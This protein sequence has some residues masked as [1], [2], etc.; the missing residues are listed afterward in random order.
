[1][2]DRLGNRLRHIA[3]LRDGEQFQIARGAPK[4]QRVIP[5]MAYAWIAPRT[6]QAANLSGDV[7]VVN[8]QTL[9]RQRGIRQTCHSAR[10]RLLRL[11]AYRT[12]PALSLEQRGVFRQANSEIAAQLS[13]S[14]TVASLDV[15]SGKLPVEKTLAANGAKALSALDGSQPQSAVAVGEVVFRLQQTAPRAADMSRW[16][17]LQDKFGHRFLSHV[18]CGRAPTHGRQ[19]CPWARALIRRNPAAVAMVPG[20]A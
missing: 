6:E 8:R 13:I 12:D 18:R 2:N 1:M 15:I 5:E 7:V 3:K 14:L 20:V 4:K 17:G 19:T 16:K 10:A 9:Y 11:L